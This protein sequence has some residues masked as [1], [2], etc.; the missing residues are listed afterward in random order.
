MSQCH[1]VERQNI[2]A[3]PA[4][5][6]YATGGDTDKILCSASSE[7]D[8]NESAKTVTKV[9]ASKSMNLQGTRPTG[10]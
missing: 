8:N 3:W 7:F 2:I 5:A 10:V 6:M 9:R 1:G 4:S